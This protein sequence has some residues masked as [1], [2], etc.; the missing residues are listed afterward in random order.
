VREP[1]R[2]AIIAV[3]LLSLAVAVGLVTYMERPQPKQGL[4]HLRIA[5]AMALPGSPTV[6]H[7]SMVHEVV[8]AFRAWYKERYGA[9]VV[10]SISYEDTA[11]VLKRLSGGRPPFD[12]WWGGTLEAFQ[13]KREFLLPF[14]SSA[15]EELL[16]LVPNATC[17]NC[18]IMDLN[19]TT[20]TWYAWCFY[21]P[22]LLYDPEVLPNPPRSWPELTNT[23][24]ENKVIAPDPKSDPFSHGVA[25]AIYAS[26]AWRLGNEN[27][28]WASAWNTSTLIWALSA[29]L[30]SEPYLDALQLVAGKAWAMLCPDVVAYHMI[31]EAGY[32][33]LRVAYLNGTLLFPCPVAVLRGSENEEAAKAFVDFLLFKEGQAIVAKHLMPVRPDVPTREPVA[34]PYSPDFPAVGAFNRTF[35]ELAAGF[36]NDYLVCWLVKVYDGS[37]KSDTLK[38]AW[39]WV[40]KANATAGANEE[41]KR[42]Y[43]MALSNLTLM[44]KHVKRGDFDKIYRETNGWSK[45]EDYLSAWA[46][47]ARE[48]YANAVE[49]AK[50]SV[51]AASGS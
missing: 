16:S 11:S 1:V 6:P 14:N 5:Y 37:G 13:A 7:E 34:N 36:V 20:P 50:K 17:H 49:N 26:E 42:Y 45:K 29:S 44:A 23:R 33:G 12:I 35:L 4:A 48:A 46:N 2:A 25:I 22:C 18:P 19:G 9:D 40:K 38:T 43:K 8:S 10:V 31:L 15:K 47:A 3:V 30:A 32:T 24:L 21:A 28:G 41:A 39:W 27:L 51:E